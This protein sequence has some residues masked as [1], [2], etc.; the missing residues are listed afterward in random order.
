MEITVS[1]DAEGFGPA[2]Q[3]GPRRDEDLQ[4]GHDL[5]ERA[6]ERVPRVASVSPSGTKI[7]ASNCCHSGAPPALSAIS[8]AAINGIKA[9]ML[10]RL[11]DHFVDLCLSE[12]DQ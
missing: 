1:R 11:V 3:H 8:P 5:R 6:P 2:H 4:V 9:V 12:D 10:H 7:R